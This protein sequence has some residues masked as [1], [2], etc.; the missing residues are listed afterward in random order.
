M[1]H[2][3]RD[4]QRSRYPAIKGLDVSLF[5]QQLAFLAANF[6]I[7]RMEDL[8]EALNGGGLPANA[9]LLTFDDR[10]LDHYTTVF[11]LLVDMDIQGSFFPP[12]AI[13]ETGRV[14]DVNKI[15]FILAAGESAAI[16]QQ[17][18]KEIGAIRGREF[19]IPDTATLLEQ[20]A[21]PNRF[22]D[23][24]VVF[25]K[26]ML[27]TVL[28]ERARAII[29]DR[30][31]QRFVG[32]SETVFAKELYCDTHQM[33]AMKKH[34]MFVGLHGSGHE[35]LGNMEKAEYEE[36][37]KHALDYMDS[38]RLLD[39]KAW[40]MNYP[41]GSWSDGVVEFIRANGCLAGLTTE[42]AAADLQKHKRL[43]LPRLDT[44]D[45]PPVS[46]KYKEQR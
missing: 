4:L 8:L 11:P 29:A 46:E 33:T 31:F 25:I 2:Y 36:D 40:V 34:G 37:I 26:R 1:Y 35:W 7:I 6:T 30:L 12:S 38:V 32:V 23:G 14:L 41:Y 10:Y 39:K 24:E 28:P 16:N 20:Y 13:L 22:D 3:V 42:V 15:H 45:F 27:Q 44:N 5:R 21:I 17:L 19:E 43:L 18:I 9:A